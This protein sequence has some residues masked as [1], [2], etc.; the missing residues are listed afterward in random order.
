LYN[1]NITNLNLSSFIGFNSNNP[2]ITLRCIDTQ[3]PNLTYSLDLN[4]VNLF[5]NATLNNTL[6]NY[7]LAN[8]PF[9]SYEFT[10]KCGDYFGN[11]T[12]TLNGN[13]YR[14]VI[15][16]IDEKNNSLFDVRNITGALI[17]FDDNSSYY[18]FKQYNTSAVNITTISSSKIR[19]ELTYA[20]GIILRY[21][22]TS[23]FNESIRV[24]ANKEGVTHYQQL[25]YSVE[26][27][28][29]KIK[30]IF[31]KCYVTGDQTRFAYQDSKSL[32]F[33]TIDSTYEL[34][35]TSDSVDTYLAVIDGGLQ[36]L[37]NID[38]L[39]FRTTQ[40]TVNTKGEALSVQ[41][42][43]TSNES[44]IY[45]KNLNNDTKSASLL[46][47]RMDTRAT[48]YTQ[49]EFSNPNEWLLYFNYMSFT[50]ITDNTL[51]YIELTTTKNDGTVDTIKY[52][53]NNLGK[54]G[55]LKPEIAFIVALILIIFGL[56]FA[57]AK[58]TLSWFGIVVEVIALILLA[59]STW[60]WYI[61]LLMFSD[62][63]LIVYTFII[64]GNQNYP[65]IGA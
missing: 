7:S 11:T 26:E 53:F 30:N 59:L 57:S 39:V 18:N 20:A 12:Q 60:E 6:F 13:L 5:F 2:F 61:L 33:Y 14:S 15:Y 64:M 36:S 43:T 40:Y 49:T 4:E 37:F 35:T 54:T 44:I 3:S 65:T 24:C 10:Y 31:S 51:F 42:S 34:Y 41:K 32:K 21:I 19:I 63:I 46:I 22:D 17:Y 27:R 16:L 47:K 29:I 25:A 62:V 52:Y 8:T 1:P 23:L 45:Y 56:T 50:N 55:Q 58:V 48:I 38:A 28:S 9:Y